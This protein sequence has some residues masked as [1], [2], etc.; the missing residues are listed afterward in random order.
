MESLLLTNLGPLSA[1]LGVNPILLVA[2]F[3]V[4]S[5]WSLIWKGVGLWYAARNHQ[6]RWFI[7]MLIVNT[8]GIL[9]IIYILWFRADKRPGH[10]PSLFEKKLDGQGEGPNSLS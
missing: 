3:I 10:T 8:L 7:A 2:L 4:V 6:R 1:Q 5:A 9:E